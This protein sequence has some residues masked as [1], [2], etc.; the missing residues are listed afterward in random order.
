MK[1]N[2]KG[3]SVF[4]REIIE[5][6]EI[7]CTY[8]GELSSYSELQKKQTKYNLCGAGSYILE[9]KFKEN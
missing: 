5:K 7:I 3:R 8:N 2:E 6:G 1:Q 4:T 9:F